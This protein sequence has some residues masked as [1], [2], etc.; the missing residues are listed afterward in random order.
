MRIA[1]ISDIHGNY[2]AL[3]H[4]LSD[5]RRAGAD[6]IACLGD[7]AT[8]GPRPRDVL[9]VLRELGCPCI[10]GNH[11]AFLVDPALVAHYTK[12]PVI[13]DA[14]EWCR[15]QL[16]A[17]DLAF[18]RSFAPELD[19]PLTG[20]RLL[21]L[22]H[23]SPDSNTQDVLA[24]TGDDELERLLGGRRADVMAGGHTHIQMLR[25]H[26]GTWVVNPGSVGMPFRRYVAGARPEIMAHAEYAIVDDSRGSIGVELR[27]VPLDRVALREQ[28]AAWPAPPELLRN[29]LLLQYA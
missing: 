24:T 1:L 10:L 27:R 21:H 25:Q 29:D 14:V 12:A 8:L 9:R 5:A 16:S 17:E 23:G 18:V 19:I 26:R 6:Q 4:V 7:V 28:A 13:V 2:L 22:F 11:D 20:G 3:E 15:A